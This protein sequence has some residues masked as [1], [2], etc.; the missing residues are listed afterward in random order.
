M[1]IED[2]KKRYFRKVM[3]YPKGILTHFGDCTAYSCYVCDCGLIRDLVPILA[4]STP[5]QR[6]N[7]EKML[8]KG[9]MDDSYAKHEVI[10]TVLNQTDWPDKVWKRA[11]DY[12]KNHPFNVKD[13]EDMLL[14]MGFKIAR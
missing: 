13:F 7:I 5:R 10:T 4:R 1:I 14:A 6:K 3:G 11:Q 9:F 12:Q 8:P 2:L